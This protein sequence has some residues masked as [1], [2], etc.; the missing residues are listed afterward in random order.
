MRDA[1]RLRLRTTDDDVPAAYYRANARGPI[2]TPDV[3]YPEG[4]YTRKVHSI[5]LTDALAGET[6]LL[7][8]VDDEGRFFD[9]Y[10]LGSRHR[11]RPPVCSVTHVHG[12]KCYLCARSVPLL[13]AN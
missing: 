5:Y 7:E 9:V 12:L 8:P 10:V 6:V 1:I 4:T 13:L 2:V 3:S 11:N